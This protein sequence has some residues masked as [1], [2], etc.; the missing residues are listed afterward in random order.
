MITP[1]NTT[2]ILQF[3]LSSPLGLSPCSTDAVQKRQPALSQHH[4]VALQRSTLIIQI[5]LEQNPA[6][7]IQ[8]KQHLH[9]GLVCILITN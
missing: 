2:K 3:L 8:I 6:Q 4:S 9:S 5:K 1:D 7:S